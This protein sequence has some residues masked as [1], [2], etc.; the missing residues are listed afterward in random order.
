M[1][2]LIASYALLKQDLARIFE[3][4]EPSEKNFDVFSHRIF[5][6]LLRACTEVE[7]ICKLIFEANGIVLDQRDTNMIRYSDLEGAMRLSE[8]SVECTV[9]R[10]HPFTPFESFRHPARS[11]RS[12]TW[13]RAYNKVKHNRPGEFPAASLRSV[14]H[15]VGGVYALLVAQIGPNFDDLLKIDPSGP[16]FLVVPSLFSLERLPAWNQDEIYDFDWELL[17]KN[18]EPYQKHALAVRP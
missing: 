14:I 12:P 5:E 17:S 2:N 6:L 9:V 4:I 11:E 18:R 16:G 13:Y 15:A 7:A 8:I 3:F 10:H 1:R